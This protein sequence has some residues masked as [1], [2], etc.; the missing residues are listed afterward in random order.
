MQL[1]KTEELRLCAVV[2]GFA[3]SLA[4]RSQTDMRQVMQISGPRACNLALIGLCAER[5]GLHRDDTR[6]DWPIVVCRI[7]LGR[8][9]AYFRRSLFDVHA[10]HRRRFN[11][12]RRD[13]PQFGPPARVHAF[14]KRSSW[15]CFSAGSATGAA[16][17][18][19]MTER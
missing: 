2:G 5:H 7:V 15:R 16:R 4:A 12:L 17:P 14:S 9:A 8:A 6:P 19:S 11:L 3:L 1:G 13:R 18:N 10:Q